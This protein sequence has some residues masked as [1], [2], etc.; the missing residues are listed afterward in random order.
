[1]YNLRECTEKYK[2]YIQVL[3]VLFLTVGCGINQGCFL[4]LSFLSHVLVCRLYDYPILGNMWSSSLYRKSWLFMMVF[5]GTMIFPYF[6]NHGDISEIGHYVERMAPFLLF[7]IIAKDDINIPKMVWIG[8]IISII[9]ICFDTFM[10]PHYI[11]GRLMGTF[12]WPLGLTSVL[13]TMLPFLLFGIIMYW[14][15][16]FAFCCISFIVFVAGCHII[17][18]TGTRSAVIVMAVVFLGM[19][20]LIIKAQYWK[21]LKFVIPILLIVGFGVTCFSS[22]VLETRIHN[23]LQNDGRVYLMQ[24][25][26]QIFKEYPVF[27]IGTKKW[28]EV[29]H[30]RFELPGREKNI[31]SPHNIFLQS[32]NENGLIGLSG[33]LLLLIFQWHTMLKYGVISMVD[34]LRRLNWIGGMLLC[35]SAII[36]YGFFDYAFFGRYVMNLFWFYWGLTVFIIQRGKQVNTYD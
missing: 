29:Y 22:N 17:A 3:P 21:V 20:I 24:V 34:T 32:A 11:E 4:I 5:I 6:F 18:M 10:H 36:V 8:F 33:F 35:F 26:E 23:Q 27:G 15:E 2:L 16:N 31:Q 28:G 25:S 14:K 12:A 19:L 30:N 7:G 13:I 9:Y 1:M